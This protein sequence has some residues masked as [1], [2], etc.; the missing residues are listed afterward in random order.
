M[1]A[2]HNMSQPSVKYTV[3]SVYL[4]SVCYLISFTRLFMK[5]NLFEILLYITFIKMKVSGS[6]VL[7]L[8]TDVCTHIYN[9]YIDFYMGGSRQ[10]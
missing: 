9:H 10:K 8:H 2:I 1:I 3:I 5:L 4:N 6:T 7:L